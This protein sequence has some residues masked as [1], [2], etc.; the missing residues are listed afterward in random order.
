M[1]LREFLLNMRQEREKPGDGNIIR[2]GAGR[3]VVAG[4]SMS[5]QPIQET[6]EKR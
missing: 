6:K 4:T 2:Q 3:C 1:I 5:V